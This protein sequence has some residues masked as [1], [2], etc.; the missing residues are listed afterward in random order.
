MKLFYSPLSPY[1]RKVMIVAHELGLVDRIEKLEHPTTPIDPN[2][3]VLAQN[4]VG[5]I[6]ALVT[7]DAGTLMDSRVICRYLNDV[8]N[9]AFYGAGGEDYPLLAREALAEGITDS[10]LLAAYEARMRPEEIRFQPWVDGQYTKIR[11]GL[12]AFDARVSELGGEFTIDQVALVAACGH[13]DYRHP[14]LGWRDQCPALA[15]WLAGMSQRPSVL[16]TVPK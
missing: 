11:N 13:L 8:G 14:N 5:R 7:E 3:E 16:A 6:P 15:E 10:S 2:P 12:K 1:V 4:P 9:G